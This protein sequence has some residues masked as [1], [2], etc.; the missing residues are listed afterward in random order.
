M[1]GNDLAAKYLPNIYYFDKSHMVVVMEFLDGFD[2][3]DH[4]LVL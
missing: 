2:L 1:L 4:V 3:L